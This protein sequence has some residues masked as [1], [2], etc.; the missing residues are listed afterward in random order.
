[1]LACRLKAVEKSVVDGG[2]W[3]AT[4]LEL[5]PPTDSTLLDRDEE[6]MLRAEEDLQARLRPAGGRSEYA[7]GNEKGRSKGKPSWQPWPPQPK[8]KG[9]KGGKGSGKRGKDRLNHAEQVGQDS[10]W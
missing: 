6:E 5:I 1:M 9:E 8:G 4:F 7:K 2:W 3:R 10:W